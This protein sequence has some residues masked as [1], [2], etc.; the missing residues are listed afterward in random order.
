MS[1][2]NSFNSIVFKAKSGTAD[3]MLVTE[4]PVDLAS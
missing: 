3:L 4:S 2:R 1:G